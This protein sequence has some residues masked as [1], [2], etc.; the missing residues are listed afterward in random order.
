MI[1]GGEGVGS[2]LAVASTPAL[3]S[4]IVSDESSALEIMESIPDSGLSKVVTVHLVSLAFATKLIM[5]SSSS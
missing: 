4:L 3:S 2:L 5:A 1:R